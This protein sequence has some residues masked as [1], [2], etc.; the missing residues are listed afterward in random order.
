MN[1][2]NEN[3]LIVGGAGY[4][5]SHVARSFGKSGNE[6]VLLDDLSTGL[7]RR[8]SPHQTFVEM[9]ARDTRGLIEVISNYKITGIVHLA[10]LRQARE[11]FIKPID[12]WTRNVGVT[13]SIAEAVKNTNIQKLVYSSSCSVYGDSSEVDRKTSLKPVSPY[14][15]TKLVGEEILQDLLLEKKV[16]IGI[17]RYFN[18]IGCSDIEPLFDET[19]G[20]LLPK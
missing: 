4:I 12:Y 9:D 17:L 19:S 10:A 8:I 1:S 18:V 6:I 13:L 16:G 7:R 11:S 5:G 15:K 2:Q 14:G 20:A 3:W